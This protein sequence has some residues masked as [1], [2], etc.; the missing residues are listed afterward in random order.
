MP[1]KNFEQQVREQLED[2]SLDSAPEIWPPVNAALHPNKKRRWLIWFFG[3]AVS[4]L[5]GTY[6]IW[7]ES[8]KASKEAVIKDAKDQSKKTDLQKSTA[9]NSNKKRIN[10]DA[11][12]K[13]DINSNKIIMSHSGSSI[14][15]NRNGQMRINDSI[16]ITINNGSNFQS[17]KQMDLGKIPHHIISPNTVLQNY[18]LDT[19]LQKQS[20][21]LIIQNQNQL[22]SGIKQKDSLATLSSAKA[23]K[24][25]D[26]K[27]WHFNIIA[28]KLSL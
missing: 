18:S 9:E 14:K 24:R 3:V 17:N 19:S 12:K 7:H 16:S 5:G 25:E 4:C 10:N 2:F 26:I 22:D 28:K 1:D 27:N 11:H 20:P 8:F 13:N 6:L 21:L 15:S 23:K